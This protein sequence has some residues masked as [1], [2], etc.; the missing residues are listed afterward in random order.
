MERE[1]DETFE[2]AVKW[3]AASMYA[4]EPESLQAR[5]RNELN[6]RDLAGQEVASSTYS[7]LLHSFNLLFQISS[8]VLNMMM[9][10][11]LHPDILRTAQAEIDSVVGRQYTP[12]IEDRDALPYILAIVKETLRWHPPLPMDIP[13]ASIEDDFYNGKNIV[14]L[15]FVLLIHSVHSGYLIP[16]N[17][18]VIPNIW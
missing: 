15:C 7:I 18:T 4:G 6:I 3:A 5:E 17:T 1:T 8:S 9:A 13:R 12:S 11:A 2:H 16:K 10:L 14:A